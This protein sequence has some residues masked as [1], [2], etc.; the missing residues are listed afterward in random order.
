MI[1]IHSTTFDLDGTVELDVLPDSPDGETRRRV[2]RVAT[3]DGGVAMND[4]GYAEGD[5][6][7]SYTWKT[8]SKAHNDAVARIVRLYPRVTVSTPSGCFLAA[9]QRF[10]PGVGESSITLLVIDKV[11]E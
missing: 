3:L 6:D 2:T 11:S 4:R 8:V 9:P 5:R 10:S 1:T 7:L